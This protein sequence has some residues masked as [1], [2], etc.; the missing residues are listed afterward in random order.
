MR[1]EFHL[2][3]PSFTVILFCS[4]TLWTHITTVLFT[5]YAI[6]CLK[7]IRKKVMTMYNCCLYLRSSQFSK[8]GVVLNGKGRSEIPL[9]N[10]GRLK[11][12]I[13]LPIS[14]PPPLHIQLWNH[15]FNF[16]RDSLWRISTFYSAMNK[17]MTANSGRDKVCS[18]A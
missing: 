8:A 5:L 17:C 3:L 18:L 2:T 13:L 15:V 4:N 10:W 16:R 7:E 12:F 9:R 11:I 6:I 1:G 14:I